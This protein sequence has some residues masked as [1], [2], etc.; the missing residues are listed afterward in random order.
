MGFLP[1]F[2]CKVRRFEYDN[3]NSSN[4][5]LRTAAWGPRTV[6]RVVRT[7]LHLYRETRLSLPA[8]EIK[9]QKFRRAK[10]ITQGHAPRSRRPRG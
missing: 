10:L 3:N 8:L 5:G 6:L 2:L 4:Y 7:N 1:D 9:K